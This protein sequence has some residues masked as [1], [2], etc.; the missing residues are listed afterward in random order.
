MKTYKVTLKSTL[1][2]GTEVTVIT[3]EKDPF[4]TAFTEYFPL[5]ELAEFEIK[6]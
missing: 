1:K 5:A 6:N 2:D 3:W 4:R